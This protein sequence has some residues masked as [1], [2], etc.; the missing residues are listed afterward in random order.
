[1]IYQIS[2]L[3]NMNNYN[4]FK[5]AIVLLLISTLLCGS[6]VSAIKPTEKSNNAVLNVI[7]CNRQYN[8]VE[9]HNLPVADVETIIETLMS[10]HYTEDTFYNAQQNT[11]DFLYKNN[12][13]SEETYQWLS[14]QNNVH[15]KLMKYRN[16]VLNKGIF[17]DVAN[18]FSGMFFAL[19][20]VRE[21]SFGEISLREFPFFNGTL[22][23]QISLYNKF[24]GDGTMFT[25]GFL[26]FKYNYEYNESLYDFP[27]F[28]EFDGTAL[29]YTGVLIEVELVDGNYPGEYIIGV[30]MS[31][32]TIWNKAE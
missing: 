21:S 8:T 23:A 3:K 13:I 30:G 14:H 18:V 1:M 19:K 28:P 11:I 16:D 6:A 29:V 12:I 4:F 26:G 31:A 22:S 20:G 2:G 9:Q 17:F 10:S 32:L 24:H 25:L 5:K 7:S 27:Y 15:E